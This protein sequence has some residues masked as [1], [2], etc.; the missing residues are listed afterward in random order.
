MIVFD[1][2]EWCDGCGEF[3][4]YFHPSL[5]MNSCIIFSPPQ[6]IIL[7]YNSHYYNVDWLNYG[8]ILHYY[9]G[10]GFLKDVI[11]GLKP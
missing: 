9:C 6:L 3:T 5:I 8:I 4:V 10:M 2:H 11:K 7:Q 1:M